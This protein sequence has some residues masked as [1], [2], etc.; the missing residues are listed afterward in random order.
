MPAKVRKKRKEQVCLRSP[1]ER[2]IKDYSLAAVG[3]GAAAFAPT[4]SAAVVSTGVINQNVPFGSPYTVNIGGQNAIRVSNSSCT[5]FFVAA[6]PGTGAGRMFA[7]PGMAGG[8]ALAVNAGQNV[9]GTLAAFNTFALLASSTTKGNSKWTGFLGN[10]KYLGFS[11]GTGPN[12]HYGW[13]QLNVTLSAP[14]TAYT[15]TVVEAAYETIAGQPLAAGATSD[16]V[17]PTTPAPNSLWLM[18][19]GAA[20]LAGLEVMRRRRTV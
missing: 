8:E 4:A 5:S 13:V 9:P 14:H 20:G 6:H 19:L 17:P 10:T 16:V 2:R 1:L 11:F 12:I 18:A 7:R 15:V 3:I